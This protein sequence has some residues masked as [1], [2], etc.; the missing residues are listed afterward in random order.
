MVAAYLSATNQW[1][2]SKL[3]LTFKQLH[4]QK[5]SHQARNKSASKSPI[6]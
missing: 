3:I 2:V 6:R 5:Y 4:T 1:S